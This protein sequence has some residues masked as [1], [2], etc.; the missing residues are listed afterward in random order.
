MTT[1]QIDTETLNER[2]ELLQADRDFCEENSKRLM[3]RLEEYAEHIVDIYGKLRIAERADE[4]QT[5]DRE[6]N[7][8]YWKCRRCGGDAA[9]SGGLIEHDRDCLYAIL[10]E[11]LDVKAKP[12]EAEG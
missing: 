2:I 11:G 12:E 6:L 7:M 5:F 1:R 4:Y 8:R 9:F 10:R 3:G